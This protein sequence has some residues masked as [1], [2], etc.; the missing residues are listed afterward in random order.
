[1]IIKGSQ[2]P[3]Q[4]VLPPYII[5]HIHLYLLQLFSFFTHC[6]VMIIT[7]TTLHYLCISRL[8]GFVK[9]SE[10]PA[11]RRSSEGIIIMWF[12]SHKRFNFFME[13][14]VAGFG[15][16][17]NVEKIHFSID[18]WLFIQSVTY[19]FHCTL[20]H[21]GNNGNNI[22]GRD[23]TFRMTCSRTKNKLKII[24]IFLFKMLG[25]K[26]GREKVAPCHTVLKFRFFSVSHCCWSGSS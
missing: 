2:N 20:S 6:T 25:T 12:K 5:V 8:N 22:C 4:N 11:G 14:T 17:L 3:D 15:V 10:E 1:M 18:I 23:L 26:S 16:S 19:I 9:Y 24:I 13:W 21:I 7:Y